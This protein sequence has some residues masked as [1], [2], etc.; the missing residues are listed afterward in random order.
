M[1]M[2]SVWTERMHFNA[3]ASDHVVSMDSPPPLGA[4]HAMS[5]K[6]LLLAAI[7]GCTGMVSKAVPIRYTIE[8][9]S[10]EIGRGNSE[11]NF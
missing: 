8:L 9:N 3:E 5:P 6:Q 4:G 11:F 1:K 10:R 2:K 7:C